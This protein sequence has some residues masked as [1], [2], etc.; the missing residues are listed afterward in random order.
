M[1]IMS[2]ICGHMEGSVTIATHVPRVGDKTEQELEARG[3]KK[4]KK[5]LVLHYI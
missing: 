1:V 4:G 5:R 3:S 2:P